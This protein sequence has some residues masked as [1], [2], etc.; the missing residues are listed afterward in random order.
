[1]DLAVADGDLVAEAVA[2]GFTGGAFLGVAVDD[3]RASGV[4]GVED[5]DEREHEVRPF[6]VGESDGSRD[7]SEG[8]LG[9]GACVDPD[10]AAGFFEGEGV[11]D[12]DFVG[13][14]GFCGE[15]EGWAVWVEPV[16][17]ACGGGGEG[18]EEGGLSGGAGDHGGVAGAAG[19]GRA[20]LKKRSFLR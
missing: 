15:V 1:M 6:L 3:E 9:V 17:E 16:G 10:D 18:E 12:G 8:E 2:D 20:T 13:V 4:V 5:F 7:V 19:C 14:G 11:G